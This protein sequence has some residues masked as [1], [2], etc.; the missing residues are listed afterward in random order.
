MLWLQ[1]IV[2]ATLPPSVSCFDQCRVPLAVS[3][4][5][6]FRLTTRTLERGCLAQALRA[7]CTLPVLFAPVWHEVGVLVDGGVRDTT[8]TFSFALL[9]AL[10]CE[11]SLAW[12]DRGSDAWCV[13]PTRSEADVLLLFHSLGQDDS[14]TVVCVGR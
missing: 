6:A 13:F 14:K 10:W 5:D 9:P 3:A 11:L 1:E 4:F 8:G 7:T 2:K 12:W